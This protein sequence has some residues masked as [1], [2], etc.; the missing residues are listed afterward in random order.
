MLIL[1]ACDDM[2][3]VFRLERRPWLPAG[4]RSSNGPSA[5][6][7]SRRFGQGRSVPV[8]IVPA[9]ADFDR[10]WFPLEAARGLGR[11]AMPTLFSL[12]LFMLAPPTCWRVSARLAWPFAWLTYIAPS[13]AAI[14]NHS[15]NA[16]LTRIP[17]RCLILSHHARLVV[18]SVR[19]LRNISHVGLSVSCA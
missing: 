17:S 9:V 18:N 14:T 1:V 15:A 16:S 8:V 7:P 6:L 5:V 2:C 19:Q 13:V 12:G 4:T 10:R 3:W 11:C